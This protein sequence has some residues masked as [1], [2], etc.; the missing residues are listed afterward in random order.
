MKSIV[1]QSPDGKFFR[2]IDPDGSFYKKYLGMPWERHD[3]DH[4][5]EIKLPKYLEIMTKKL[6]WKKTIY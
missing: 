5:S 1:L 6:K 4:I 3:P 2:R